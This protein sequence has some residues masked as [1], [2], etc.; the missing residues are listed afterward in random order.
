MDTPIQASEVREG[1]FI[2]SRAEWR[3][4]H[5]RLV[6]AVEMEV[7]ALYAFATAMHRFAV[8]LAYVT[9]TMAQTEGDFEKYDADGATAALAVIAAAA[10]AWLHDGSKE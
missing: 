7:A 8:C 1:N 4:R 2:L 10:R 9:S 3:G 5:S 6:L